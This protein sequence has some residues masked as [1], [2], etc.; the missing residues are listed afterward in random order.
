METAREVMDGQRVVTADA[1]KGGWRYDFEYGGR[2]YMETLG[3]I[4]KTRAK[5]L[6]QKARVSAAEGRFEE[7]TKKKED[8][9]FNEVA[10][11]YL[12]DYRIKHR[13]ASYERHEY[14]YRAVKK[15]FG[16]KRLSSIT[17]HSLSRYI[18]KRKDDG[19]SEVTINRELAFL[20]NLFTVAIEWGKTTE[21]PVKKV[22][23]FHE[24]N[25]RTR[26]L[27]EEEEELLLAES[28][29][30]IYRVILTAIHTGM[31]KSELLSLTWG[32][33]NFDHRIITVE[34]AYAKSKETRSVPMSSRLTETLLPIRIA[35]PNAPVFLNSQGGPYRDISRSFNSA[36]KR[37]GIQD[38]TFHDL[39]HTFASRLVMRGVDLTTVKELMGHKH[40]NMT[41]RYAHLSPGHKHSAIA[42][43]D[44]APPIFPPSLE[45][46]EILPSQVIET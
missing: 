35:D 29:P 46:T 19:M 18:R 4:S 28:K 25:G 3:P 12:E 14:A 6:Y 11:E 15:V 40:I 1:L 41:L 44:Q 43:L 30:H 5:E 20:K 2:R 10:Q 8:P 21:N 7:V 22:R 16:G 37:A 32:K 24:D 27:T 23:L 26:F 39:R 42:V 38:F 9:L 17:P 31:R 36:V 34:S 13:Q 45:M 33:V